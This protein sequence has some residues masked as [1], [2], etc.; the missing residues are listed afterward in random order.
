MYQYTHTRLQPI[1]A[2]VYVVG[3]STPTSLDIDFLDNRSLIERYLDKSVSEEY[4][5]IPKGSSEIK[6]SRK[7]RGRIESI[8]VE[9]HSPLQN[10]LD[11][12]NNLLKVR[13]YIVEITV[14]SIDQY[15]RILFSFS[16]PELQKI[17]D[18]FSCFSKH[19]PTPKFRPWDSFTRIP[20]ANA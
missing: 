5:Y 6:K 10:A 14:G 11:R 15:G 12:L 3:V 16:D 18:T 9:S 13:G 19:Q 1:R 8:K 2:T 7:F 4:L 17:F 20:I